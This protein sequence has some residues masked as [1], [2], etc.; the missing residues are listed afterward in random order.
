MARLYLAD[1]TAL[2]A[3]LI[4]RARMPDAANA[5]TDGLARALVERVRAARRRGGLDALLSQ[6]SLTTDEGVV[7]MCLAEALL[8]V[9]DAGTAD[10]LI[11]DKL[12]QADWERHLGESSSLFVN[13]STWALMLTGRIVRLGEDH[14]D[15]TTI[16][17]RVVARSGEPVIRQ[18]MTFAM[19]IMGDQF[20]LGRTIE[21]ALARGEEWARRGCRFSFDM[22]G[23]AA[24]TAADAERYFASLCHRHRGDRP[25]RGRGPRRAA[26]A[27]RS[28]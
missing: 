10:R 4:D 7:L 2:V 15:W 6:Y 14:A 16:F 3:Q 28:R 27:T 1:E 25:A 8:R 24:V 22:L 5:T 17:G 18:A 11:R 13:A 12:D 26:R 21:E 20:V 9:P 19:R 23:E